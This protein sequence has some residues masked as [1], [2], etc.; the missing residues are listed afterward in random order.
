M[1]DEA[2]AFFDKYKNNSLA[3]RL[4]NSINNG[5]SDLSNFIRQSNIADENLISF[6]QTWDRAGDQVEAYR[7][8][9]EEAG[10]TTSRF[11]GITQDA[12]NLIKS[13]GASLLS[14]GV[15]WMIG[16]AIELGIKGIDRFVVNRQ[17][18]I[19]QDA[20]EAQE[21]VDKLQEEQANRNELYQDK[22]LLKEYQ[23]LAGRVD[24]SGNNISLTNAEF[25]R[26]K[27]LSNQIASTFPTLIS[28]YSATGDAI[29]KCKN[30]AA[31]FNYQI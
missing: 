6:I 16:Q 14:V 3:T 18:Y 7:K 8:H 15:D 9:L 28:G 23:S 27:E 22:D 26:Y 21:R 4:T 13:F 5:D 2:T 30:N 12:K 11:S 19:K 10:Q 1:S 20:T 31:E 17:N 29:L 25:E 24:T